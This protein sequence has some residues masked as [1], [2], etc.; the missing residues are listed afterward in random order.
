M[1]DRHLVESIL[2]RL[3][4]IEQLSDRLAKVRDLAERQELG[5]RLHREFAVAR[6]ALIAITGTARSV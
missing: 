3:E 6:N 4:Y 2:A 1:V 5:E